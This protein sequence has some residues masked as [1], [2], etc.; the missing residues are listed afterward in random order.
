VR[1]PTAFELRPIEVPPE[2]RDLFDD[3]NREAQW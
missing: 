1:K 3:L 2:A